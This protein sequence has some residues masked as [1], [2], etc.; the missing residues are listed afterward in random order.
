MTD[1]AILSMNFN[2]MNI[3]WADANFDG[4]NT[5]NL[6]DLA[7]LALNYGYVTDPIPQTANFSVQR[8]PAAPRITTVIPTP[9]PA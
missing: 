9:K 2:K 4:D 6:T 3:G 5:T 7:L 8:M 1:L